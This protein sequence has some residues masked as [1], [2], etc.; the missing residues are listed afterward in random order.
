MVALPWSFDDQLLARFKM[1]Q[2]YPPKK[3]YV[4]IIITYKE[5]VAKKVLGH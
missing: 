5:L 4:A 3:L 1:E 2:I